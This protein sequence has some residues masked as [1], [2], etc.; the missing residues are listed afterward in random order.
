MV[1]DL[2]D[3]SFMDCAGYGALV[4]SASILERRGGSMVLMNPVG[5]P[6]RLLGLIDEFDHGLCAPIRYGGP[7]SVRRQPGRIMRSDP[8]EAMPRPHQYERQIQMNHDNQNRRP[9]C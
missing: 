2:T 4:A 8:D 7:R 9:S 5:E 6:Q 3:L 1:V